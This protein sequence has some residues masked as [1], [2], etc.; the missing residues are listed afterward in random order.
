MPLR[1]GRVRE[2][3]GRFPGAQELKL[4]PDF[5]LLF[6]GAFLKS[7]DTLPPALI[8]ERHGGVLFLQLSN[9]MALF[10]QRLNALRAAQR[11]PSVGGHQYRR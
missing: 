6:A 2:D 7:S 5:H 10:K 4:F 9:F 8:F 3:E 11:D 1:L